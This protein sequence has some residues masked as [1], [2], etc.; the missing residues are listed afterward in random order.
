M[1][2]IHIIANGEV[3]SP[4]HS[5]G[6]DSSRVLEEIMDANP[7]T[8][9]VEELLKK[10]VSQEVSKQRYEIAR[11]YC[12]ANLSTAWARDPEV[13]R[14][15]PSSISWRVRNEGDHQGANRQA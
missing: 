3:Y 7:R 8:P 2:G 5:F 14:I 11:G 15:Q 1:T 10:L 4:R 6:V 9:E 13:T 12:W